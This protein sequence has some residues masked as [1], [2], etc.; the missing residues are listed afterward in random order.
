MVTDLKPAK[1]LQNLT[2]E[3]LLKYFQLTNETKC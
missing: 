2:Y 3:R 1:I